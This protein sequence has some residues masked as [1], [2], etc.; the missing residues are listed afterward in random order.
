MLP[1]IHPGDLILVEKFSMGL[2]SNYYSI[3]NEVHRIPFPWQRKLQS[4]DVIVFK[5]PETPDILIKRIEMIEN[6]KYCVYGD[7]KESS[8]DS[9][10]FGCISED[11]IIG[12]YIFRIH[13]G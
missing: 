11:R 8:L 5:Q 2:I 6:N 3:N 12:R 13:N 4:G 9:R 10:I 1:S 7:N